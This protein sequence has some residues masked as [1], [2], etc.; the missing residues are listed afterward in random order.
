MKSEFI[1][2]RGEDLL[3]ASYKPAGTVLKLGVKVPFIWRTS[4][5]VPGKIFRS[6]KTRVASRRLCTRQQTEKDGVAVGCR[7][8]SL[9]AQSSLHQFC[10]RPLCWPPKHFIG[11][12][13][14]Q[15]NPIKRRG[16]NYVWKLFC[17]FQSVLTEVSPKNDTTTLIMVY[18]GHLTTATL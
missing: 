1:V 3:P 5:D 17:G 4:Q 18:N 6:R 11:P 14:G 8:I 15:T 12:R 7:A 16:D 10:C 9:I 2:R 13:R